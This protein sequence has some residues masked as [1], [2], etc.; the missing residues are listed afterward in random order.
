MKAIE[1]FW[2]FECISN[3]CNSS[4]MTFIPKSKDPLELGD[5]SPINLIGCYYII[6]SKV[7]AER[8]K[9]VMDKVIVSRKNKKS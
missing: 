8:I 5:F 4:F 9:K 7:L 6:I 1:Y 2:E 3:G